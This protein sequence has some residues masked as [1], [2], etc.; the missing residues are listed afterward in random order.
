MNNPPDKMLEVHNVVKR[1]GS[2]TAVDGVSFS[3]NG[4]EIFGL[5]GPNGAGKSTTIRMLTTLTKPTAGELF[6]DGYSVV[7]DQVEVKRRIGVVPQ[8]N[9]FEQ[10]F[11]GYSEVS[12]EW[13]LQQN[14]G[15]LV[16]ADYTRD[17][18]GFNVKDFGNVEKFKEKLVQNIVLSKTDVV[19]KDR[20]YIIPNGL[21]GGDKSYLGA[22]YLA[23]WFYPDQFKELDPDKVLK[24]YFEKW[25][26]V[27]FQGKWAYPPPTK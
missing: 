27:P 24:E 12:P 8:Q 19:K 3:V 9:N 1:Y 16:V 11:K 4:G 14:P 23:K 10:E 21:L 25:M 20:I 26:D 6:V 2:V 5:L 17:L 13:I 15:V 22:Q 7:N 18:V